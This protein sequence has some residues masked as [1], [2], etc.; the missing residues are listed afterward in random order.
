MSYS[1]NGMLKF[2][3]KKKIKI[4]NKRR[5]LHGFDTDILGPL[6]QSHSTSFYS[7]VLHNKEQSIFIME[8]TGYIW[9]S[10]NHYL[11]QGLVKPM[12][13]LFNLMILSYH[14]P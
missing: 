9:H 8:D 2:R 11:V 6:T 7:L 4:N 5:I 14:I 12:I 10:I 1:A 13:L 3:I